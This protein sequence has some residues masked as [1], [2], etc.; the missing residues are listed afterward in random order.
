M[1]MGMD[2]HILYDVLPGLAETISAWIVTTFDR[3]QVDQISEEGT[4]RYD[5]A[6]RIQTYIIFLEREQ[7]FTSFSFAQFVDQIVCSC[8]MAK[9]VLTAVPQRNASWCISS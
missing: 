3:L 6:A 9:F 2:I 8:L 5:L 7:Q 1:V 4:T